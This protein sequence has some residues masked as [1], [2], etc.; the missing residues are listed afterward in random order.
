MS[1]RQFLHR[2]DVCFVCVHL[3]AWK[4]ARQRDV[5][6]HSNYHSDPVVDR[7]PADLA[8]QLRGWG[9][10]P[11]GGLGLILVIVIILV[12]MGRL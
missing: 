5:I 1:E 9:Y 4:N 11:G 7:C 2:V 3:S 6:D 8:L 12:L 10:Y